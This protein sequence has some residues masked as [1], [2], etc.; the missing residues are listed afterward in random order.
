MIQGEFST[1]SRASFPGNPYF[2]YRDRESSRAS[3][4]MRSARHGRALFLVSL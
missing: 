2:A 1:I 3:R 4:L